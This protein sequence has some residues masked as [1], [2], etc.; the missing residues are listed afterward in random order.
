VSDFYLIAEIKS[1][2]GN[3]GFVSV[4]S[5]TDFPD[6]F[7]KLDKVYI[8]LFQDRKEFFVDEVKQKKSSLLLKFKNF[9]SDDEVEFLVGKKI[10]ISSEDIVS[11][12]IDT[13][14]I[15]DLVGSKVL[16][17]GEH[18]GIIEDVL[19][20]PA[21]DVYVIKNLLNEEVLIPAVKEFVLS[22]DPVNKVLILQPGG[23]IYEDD[24]D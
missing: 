9:N 16:R 7:S 4:T 12:S 1:V 17:N 22:F 6:R 2:Y 3:K 15:H 13:F 18:F 21:N 11:L 24:E 14:F 19:N 8:E 23:K 10:F 20:L 5:H